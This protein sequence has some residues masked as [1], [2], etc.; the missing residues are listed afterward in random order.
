MRSIQYSRQ[1]YESIPKKKH[2]GE[3]SGKD[4][5]IYFFDPNR[6]EIY[7]LKRIANTSQLKKDH[8]DENSKRNSCADK[9][10]KNYSQENPPKNTDEDRLKRNNVEKYTGNVGNSRQPNIKN[11]KNNHPE[12]KL[13]N[14]ETDSA[15]KNNDNTTAQKDVSKDIHNDQVDEAKIVRCKTMITAKVLPLCDNIPHTPE[16]TVEPVIVKIPV[17][18]TECTVSITVMSSLRLEDAILEIERIKE[19]VY[20]EQCEFIPNSEGGMPG[21]GVLFINGFIRKNIE[22]TAKSHNDKGI[23]CGKVKHVTVKVPFNCA[24][25]VAFNTLP[26]FKPNIS[27]CEV[28]ILQTSIDA[29][30]LCEENIISPDVREQNFK[31]IEFF[32][33]KVFCELVSAEIIESDIIESKINK[34]CKTPSDQAT[35]NITEKI[36]LSLTI[37]LL[38]NQNVEISG[39]NQ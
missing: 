39:K 20:L 25:R 9:S 8:I 17:V 33:E 23:S 35:H 5:Y 2:D 12:K 18:L 1:Y 24:T 15:K 32:N 29:S 10:K 21:T 16:V 6:F 11:D 4:D 26:K 31:I 19:N 30:N 34:E 22:Y 37:K 28:E 27:N 14:S 38:Q 13:L 36:V 7:S 3:H